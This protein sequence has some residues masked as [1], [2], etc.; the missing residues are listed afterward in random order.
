MGAQQEFSLASEFKRL[1]AY[2]RNHN[3]SH[4]HTDWKNGLVAKAPFKML[5]VA[6]ME[7]APQTRFGL[8]GIAVLLRVARTRRLGEADFDLAHRRCKRII[9]RMAF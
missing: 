3:A 2:T 7:I 4:A 1:R 9:V 6:I 8:A 5:F